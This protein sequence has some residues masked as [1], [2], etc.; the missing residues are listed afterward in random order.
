MIDLVQYDSRTERTHT[1]RITVRDGR[2]TRT[3]VSVRLYGFAD[4]ARLLGATGF[5]AVEGF[6]QDGE[7]L[8]LYGRRLIVLAEKPGPDAPAKSE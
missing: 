5:A 2:V 8:T 7:P 6:G 4:F 3:G 1:K